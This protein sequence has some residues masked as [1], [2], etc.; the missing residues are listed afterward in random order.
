MDL[1]LLLKAAVL[2]ILEGATEFLPISST[3]HLIVAG[4]L[5]NFN[6]DKG[7]VFEIVIQLGA[8]LAVCWEYRSRLI[9]VAQGLTSNAK[10]QRFVLN[11]FIGFLPAAVLGLVFHSFIKTHLFSPINVAVALIVGGF[12]IL[13]IER[14][15]DGKDVV[16]KAATLDDITPLQALKVGFAQ[17][18]AMIPGTSRSGAT[19]LGGMLFGLSRKAATEFSFFL[20]IPVMLAASGYD[21]FKNRALFSA[22]D[23][24]MF[25]VGFIMAFI[26]ALIA[27]KTLIRYVANHDFRA[28][29]YYRIVF[30]TV[31]LIYFLQFA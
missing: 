16:H 18:L 14:H 4:D 19:I 15:F 24:P 1:L 10:S 9:N 27:V 21:V 8:I 22:D 2:G 31:V 12:L 25:A 6:D 28:F 3:G 30:G 17:S 11:V 26:A 23:I 29:A 7:K 20:A 13:W 5:L